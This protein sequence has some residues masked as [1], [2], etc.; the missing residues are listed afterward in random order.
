MLLCI[1]LS[2][3][4]YTG[5]KSTSVSP[6]TSDPTYSDMA[7]SIVS[8]ETTPVA[9]LISEPA[10]TP[11][12]PPANDAFLFT[13]DNFPRIDGSTATIPLIEAVTCALLGLPRSEVSANVRKTGEAYAALA[14]NDADILL[15]YDGGEKTRE[16]VNADVLFETVSIG[17]DAL[18]FLVNR[19]NPVENLTSEQVQKIFSGEYT[20]WSDLGGN[21]EPIRAFQRGE[22]SGS[23]A[24]MDKLVMRGLSMADPARIAVIGD[25]RMLIEAVAD[26]SG[27]SSSIGY[28]VYYY[29][30][31]MNQNDYIK[32]LSIDGVMPNYE[33]IQSNEYPFVSEFYSVIRKSEPANSPARILHRWMLSDEAQNLLASENYISLHADPAANMPYV[34]E[35][36][37]IYPNEEIPAYFEN[38]NPYAFAS[39]DDYGQLFF[40]LGNNKM[41]GLCTS[42]GKIVTEPVF[43]IPRL[44]T[45]SKGNKA[46]LCCR[47]DKEP[48]RGT[49]GTEYDTFERNYYPV[50]LF[51]ID[52]GWIKAFDGAQLFVDDLGT[53]LN[54]DILAVMLGGKWGAVDM[55][56]ET[57]IPFDR[58]SFA[59]IYTQNDSNIDSNGGFTIHESGKIT[60]D[61]D[62]WLDSLYDLYDANGC[63]MVSG[64]RGRPWYI[65]VDFIVSCALESM[66]ANTIYAYRGDG[67]LIG[68]L[69]LGE[70]IYPHQLV[71][72]EDY[73][74]IFTDNCVIICDSTLNVIYENAELYD[75][76][77]D[78]SYGQGL[79]VM[80]ISNAKT[81]FHRTYLPDGTRLVTWYDPE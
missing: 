45:D 6:Q 69:A 29:V 68:D 74:W 2:L 61:T 52:G 8:P 5:C 21:N 11:T 17:K 70:Y 57:V 36:H 16:Q 12:A 13:E 10:A 32:I 35:G 39:R 59:G 63:L 19:D 40:Y 14:R 73:V 55:C 34:N 41:Y 81:F 78:A 75:N 7:S 43:T 37:S 46:Y 51:A 30:T 33:T 62:Y 77:S 72:I 64:L 67:E 66:N 58:D 9:N 42:E 65:S 47:S 18:V 79:S 3:T 49:D 1:A 71:V 15:V 31:E 23:Q 28:N 60:D 24:L 26:Y 80:Y 27:G 50:L 4:G 22:G 76:E 56:G 38:V 53:E 20:N 25:M 48:T 54:S 44:L